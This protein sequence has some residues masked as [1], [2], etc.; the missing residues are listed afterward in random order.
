VIGSSHEA[1][2]RLRFRLIGR[3]SDQRLDLARRRY[4]NADLEVALVP[5]G[6]A[7]RGFRRNVLQLKSLSQNSY[8]RFRTPMHLSPVRNAG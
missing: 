8:R 6:V 1:D 2:Q 3:G 5:P 4:V 7:D